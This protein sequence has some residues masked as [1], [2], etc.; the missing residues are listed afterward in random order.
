LCD[1]F[2]K[3]DIKE[4][5]KTRKKIKNK[6]KRK[7]RKKRKKK[8][9]T[10]KPKKENKK[11]IKKYNRVNNVFFILYHILLCRV[12][13]IVLIQPLYIFKNNI[14]R[15]PR[16]ELQFKKPMTIQE[17]TDNLINE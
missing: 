6:K 13:S 2:F 16:N 8:K 12:V 14:K 9:K 15:E 1:Q 5:Q 4:K 17:T 3:F 10:K 7:K 11:K